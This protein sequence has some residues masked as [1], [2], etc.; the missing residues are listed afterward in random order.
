VGFFCELQNCAIRNNMR[1]SLRLT[2][3]SRQALF[4][5]DQML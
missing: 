1:L 4:V 5:W 3:P 2:R